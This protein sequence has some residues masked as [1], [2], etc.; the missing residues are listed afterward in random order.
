M[1]TW[2]GAAWAIALMTIGSSGSTAHASWCNAFEVCWHRNQSSS[3][4]SYY[5]APPSSVAYYAAPTTKL[6]YVAPDDEFYPQIVIRRAHDHELLCRARRPATIDRRCSCPQKKLCA[7]LCRLRAVSDLPDQL[8]GQ[9]SYYRPM[10]PEYPE[11]ELLRE[12]DDHEHELLLRAGDQLLVLVLLRC[13]LVQLPTSGQANG[14]LPVA[15]AIVPG[16]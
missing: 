9:R 13:L 7:K 4:S 5:Y 16:G 12:G 8:R 1:K 11:P 14:E 3:S 15:G 2:R 10:Q 6:H